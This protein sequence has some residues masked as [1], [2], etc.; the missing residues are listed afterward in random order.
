MF[1]PVPFD[2]G[3]LDACRGGRG[4]AGG[5]GVRL[6][7]ARTPPPLPLSVLDSAGFDEAEP[8]VDRSMFNPAAPAHFY[9]PDAS[10]EALADSFAIVEGARLPLHSAVLAMQSKVLR[11]LFLQLREPQGGAAASQ[12]RRS[13]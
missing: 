5:R 2:H 1:M 13:L 3:A 11:D 9:L 6:T 10:C 7:S 12:V 8:P 4:G